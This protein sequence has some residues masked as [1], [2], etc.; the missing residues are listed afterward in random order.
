MVE[1]VDQYRNYQTVDIVRDVVKMPQV[2]ER[3]NITPQQLQAFCQQWQIQEL[4]VFGSILRDDFRQHGANPSDV[5]LLFRH[6]PKTNMS[7]LRRVKMKTELE[8]LCH[9]PVDLVMI[10]E[11]MASHNPNRKKHILE[12]ARLLYVQGSRLSD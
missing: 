8:A 2:Y 10:S 4:A 11:V 6:L 12:S 5:D 1:Q 7:L 9:R 3:M